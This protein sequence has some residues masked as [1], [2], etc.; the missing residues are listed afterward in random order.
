MRAVVVR[1]CAV[2]TR[3]EGSLA[4]LALGQITPVQI[5]QCVG[6]DGE[7]IASIPIISADCPPSN[8]G[9]GKAPSSDGRRHKRDV[10]AHVRCFGHHV[11]S[12]T[13]AA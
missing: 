4:P 10:D 9:T 1:F 11:R 8:E 3:H 2:A 13:S 12:R 6:I 5:V 7:S